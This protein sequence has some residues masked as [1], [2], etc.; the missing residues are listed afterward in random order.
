MSRSF[1]ADLAKHV[2]AQLVARKKSPPA[3]SALTALFETLYF[4]SLKQ[5]ENQPIACRIAFI[6]RT[7]PDP[8]PPR[9]I[10][11]DRWQCCALGNDLPL[12]V[13]NLAKL[14]TAVDPWGS[15]L[16][17]DIG[18]EG[19][20]R[21]WGL[22]DQSVH[23]STYIVKEAADGP[24]M[25]G[26]FQAV[27]HGL[28]EIAVYQ[29]YLFL[30]SLTQDVLVKKQQGVFQFGPI[31]DKLMLS[32]GKLQKRVRSKVGDALYD[33]RDS[34]NEAIERM[35]VSAIC[36]ILIGIQKYRHHG[37]GGVL[38]SDVSA[39]LNPKY[40]LPYNRFADAIFRAAVLRIQHTG[41]SDEI[42]GTYLEDEMDELPMP[43]YLDESVT[44]SE[45]AD[46]NNEITG[47]VRFLASLARVDGLIWMD[48]RLRLKGFG[49]EITNR[50]DP[51]HAF[52]ATDAKATTTTQLD[53]NHFGTRHRSMLRYCAANPNG[54]GFIVSQDGDVRA[55]TQFE[56]SKVFCGTTSGFNRS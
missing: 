28:G 21:I 9:R 47:C 23:Y 32:I 22:V 7:E 55:A 13:R 50:E 24:Q 53:L 3:H 4:A 48:S 10:V 30:G 15:T 14:S 36:R 27:I 29:T 46:T 38:I 33:E 51:A 37:G 11:T 17:V 56:G 25:P 49:V 54:V 40:S 16:A 44:G 6:D 8:S 31:H 35:W 19:D 20:W 34:W 39:G 1:P 42:H 41:F 52:M 18:S 2:R 12:N 45:L 26:M 5:E 43:L